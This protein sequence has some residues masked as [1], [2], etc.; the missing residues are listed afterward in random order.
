MTKSEAY[1]LLLDKEFLVGLWSDGECLCPVSHLVLKDEHE[2]DIWED[3]NSPGF[4]SRIAERAG[5]D[6]SNIV[7]FVEW[8]D[9]EADKEN[10]SLYYVSMFGPNQYVRHVTPDLARQMVDKMVWLDEG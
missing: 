2:M 9:H 6:K 4:V 10:D 5:A 7:D 1:D 3:S 8:W